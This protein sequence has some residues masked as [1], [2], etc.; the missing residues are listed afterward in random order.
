MYY[1]ALVTETG[2]NIILEVEI[3]D[4]SGDNAP[5]I[6]LKGHATVSTRKTSRR[7]IVPQIKRQTM[8]ATSTENEF[9]DL[10]SGPLIS[11]RRMHFL[12]DKVNA[13]EIHRDCTKVYDTTRV[14]EQMR[15]KRNRRFWQSGMYHFD[16]IMRCFMISEL[17]KTAHTDELKFTVKTDEAVG[18]IPIVVESVKVVQPALLPE[19]FRS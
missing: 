16:P 13:L 9:L 2:D 15:A 7:I 12:S 6:V 18:S 1:T 17:F 11:V 5:G 14:V 8:Q 3:A 4:T 10:V 19:L